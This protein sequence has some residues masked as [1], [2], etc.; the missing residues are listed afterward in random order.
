MK[1]PFASLGYSIVRRDSGPTVEAYRRIGLGGESPVI[2]ERIYL[3]RG[4][5]DA[6]PVDRKM[7]E[8]LKRLSLLT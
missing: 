7:E 2:K 4:C 8:V 6:D 5:R 3:E 1:P